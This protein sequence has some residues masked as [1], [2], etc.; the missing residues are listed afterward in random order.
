[1]REQK[2]AASGKN[3]ETVGGIVYKMKVLTYLEMVDEPCGM[4]ELIGAKLF[5]WRIVHLRIIEFEFRLTLFDV[6]SILELNPIPVWLILRIGFRGARHDCASPPM[7]LNDTTR[8]GL[9]TSYRLGEKHIMLKQIRIVLAT[10]QQI[11]HLDPDCIGNLV[12]LNKLSK[13]IKTGMIS[14]SF[15]NNDGTAIITSF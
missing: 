3:T 9:T 7:S 2:C 6:L 13:D 1:M 14:V 4:L 12:V 10:A 8:T 15:F 5:L 11:V